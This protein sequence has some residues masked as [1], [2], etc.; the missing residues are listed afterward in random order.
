MARHRKYI[1]SVREM[2]RDSH[3]LIVTRAKDTHTHTELWQMSDGQ[4][5]VWL[6]N[7]ETATSKRLQE[8]ATA[9]LHKEMRRIHTS[10][11]HTQDTRMTLFDLYITARHVNGTTTSYDVFVGSYPTREKAEAAQK[12]LVKEDIVDSVQHTKI[13]DVRVSNDHDY[14]EGKVELNQLKD[15]KRTVVDQK[16]RTVHDAEGNEKKIMVYHTKTVDAP[17]AWPDE[18]A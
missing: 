5:T 8:E 13:R 6:C 7:Y 1:K 12:R 15:N 3:K 11:T 4:Y 14:T 16:I 17:V 10:L 9:C 2:I 18:K